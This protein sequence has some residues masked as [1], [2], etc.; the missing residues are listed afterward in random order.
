MANRTRVYWDACTWVAYINQEKEI[1]LPDGGVEDR[2]AMCCDILKNAQ[3]GRLEIATST[4]TLAEVCKLREVRESPLDNLSGFVERSYILMIPL[5][6]AVARRAQSIQTSG[7][8]KVKPPDAVHLA[9]AQRASVS[10]LHTFDKRILKL[11]GLLAGPSGDPIK[12][13]KPTE[14]GSM[15]PLFGIPVK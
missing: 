5:D 11:D 10:S 4:F 12:I 13:C 7:L 9:S 6:M 14:E 3:D 1:V 8:Y 2:F 15:T